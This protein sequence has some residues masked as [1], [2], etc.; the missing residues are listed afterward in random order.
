MAETLLPPHLESNQLN[1]LYEVLNPL[2]NSLVDKVTK[3]GNPTSPVSVWAKVFP[4]VRKLLFITL[5]KSS[6]VVKMNPLLD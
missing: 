5:W 3:L 6:L 2:T 4:M 1:T